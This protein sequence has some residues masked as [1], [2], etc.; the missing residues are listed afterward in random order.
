MPTT[1]ATDAAEVITVEWNTSTFGASSKTFFEERLKQQPGD[2]AAEAA[3]SRYRVGGGNTPFTFGE[4]AADAADPALAQW[5]DYHSVPGPYMLSPVSSKRGPGVPSGT[6]VAHCMVGS[7][8]YPG[9]SHEWWSYTPAGYA[10]GTPLP[11]LFFCDGAGYLSEDGACRATIVL[12][13]LIA[14]GDIPPT[15][16][17]FLSPGELLEPRPDTNQRGY[18]YDSITPQFADFLLADVIPAMVS[19]DVLLT[20]P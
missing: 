17:C 7:S 1:K 3:L 8:I 4:W 16:A 5:R 18:E 12:D 13:N 11:T 20:A 6:T 19:T 10:P 2:A 15:C 9:T 14:R